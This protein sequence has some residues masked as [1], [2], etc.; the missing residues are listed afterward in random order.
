MLVLSLFLLVV[1]RVSDALFPRVPLGLPFLVLDLLDV[2]GLE[3]RLDVLD[4][5]LDLCRSFLDSCF[6][7]CFFPFLFFI[8]LD[9]LLIFVDIGCFLEEVDEER[10]DG[11]GVRRS[12]FEGL[13]DVVIEVWLGVGVGLCDTGVDVGDGLSVSGAD[14]GKSV[15]FFVGAAIGSNATVIS[16]KFMKNSS[17]SIEPTI[18][19]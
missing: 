18:C 15:G 17:P 7:F 6:R 11:L 19:P 9:F 5:L 14:D 3:L 12:T 13:G 10:V 4:S 1:V 8:A 16:S 2:E